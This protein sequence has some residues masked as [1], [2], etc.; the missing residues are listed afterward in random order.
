MENKEKLQEQ[1]RQNEMEK[2]TRGWL[3]FNHYWFDKTGKRYR[4]KVD[5]NWTLL[6]VTINIEE[7]VEQYK[8]PIE[9]Q[10]EPLYIYIIKNGYLNANEIQKGGNIMFRAKGEEQSL[11]LTRG[12][13]VE[14]DELICLP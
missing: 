7:K 11:I 8:Y 3:C 2:R 5:A 12:K 6:D 4:F 1:K 10:I 14:E 9:M 13:E